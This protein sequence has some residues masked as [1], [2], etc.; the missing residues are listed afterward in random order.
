M[1][2]CNR[3]DRHC[4]PFIIPEAILEIHEA[5]V[6]YRHIHHGIYRQLHFRYAHQNSVDN[7]MNCIAPFL[8]NRSVNDLV[9]ATFQQHPKH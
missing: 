6:L 4:R 1:Y 2:G 7:G 9:R 8:R 5:P 3:S